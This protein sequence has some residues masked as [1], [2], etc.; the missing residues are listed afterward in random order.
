[1]ECT[2][3][4][5]TFKTLSNLSHHQKTAKYCLKLQGLTNDKYLCLDCGKNFTSKYYCKIHKDVCIKS[6]M[7]SKDKEIQKINNQHKKE[8]EIYKKIIKEY[9]EQII[10]LQNKLENIALKG[11]ER[12]SDY[13]EEAIIEIENDEGK[14]E[15]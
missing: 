15:L 12:V 7:K 13:Q 11:M 3:C 4:N 5:H 8:L 14:Y 1:M 2:F 9:K 6:I 10:E